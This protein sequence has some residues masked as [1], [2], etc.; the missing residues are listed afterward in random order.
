MCVIKFWQI[1]ES[2]K[3]RNIMQG[4]EGLFLSFFARIVSRNFISI[5]FPIRRKTL[6]VRNKGKKINGSARKYIEMEGERGIFIVPLLLH[7]SLSKIFLRGRFPKNRISFMPTS[8]LPC[9]KKGGFNIL[10]LCVGTGYTF[11][12]I[13]LRE[14]YVGIIRFSAAKREG[15]KSFFASLPFF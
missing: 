13:F 7:I 12:N 5:F 10:Y 11:F 1:W 3:P 8:F 14:H 9:A 15:K 4:E 2:G 6:L